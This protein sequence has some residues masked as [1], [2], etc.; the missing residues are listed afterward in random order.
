MEI[1]YHNLKLY[2]IV[3]CTVTL[4]NITANTVYVG[5]EGS[6]TGSGTLEEPFA[7]IT[8]GIS[9]LNPGDTLFV[10]AG[11]YILSTTIQISS[12]QSGQSGNPCYFFAYPGD[13]VM[14][15]FYTQ[16]FGNRGIN[17]K[18]DYW[19]LRDLIVCN[20]GDNGLYIEGAYNLIENCTFYGNDDTG[21]QISGGGSYNIVINCD[22]YNNADPDNED[23]DGFA[24]KLDIGPG[25]E[26]HG[27]RSWNNSDDGWDLYEADDSVVITNCWTFRNG[28]L[29]NESQSGG[30]GNGFKLGGNYVSGNHLVTNC[31]SFGN[32]KYG[33]HQNN[34]IGKITLYNSLG[35]ENVGR[36]YNF[37]YATADSSNL[38]NNISF[39]GGSSDKFTNCHMTTNSWQ[40]LPADEDDFLSLELKMAKDARM[41]DGSL[42]D[43]TFAKL[44]AGSN[45]IDVGTNVGLAYTGTAPDL[46]PFETVSPDADYSLHISTTGEGSVWLSPPGGTYKAGQEV[47]LVARQA[48]NYMFESWSGDLSDVNDTINLT[49]DSDKSVTANFTP[50]S[51]THPDSS[52][53]EA[54]D[55]ILTDYI[56]E[57]IAGASNGKVVR[58]TTTA[59]GSGTV[60]FSGEEHYYRIV[61]RYLDYA[62]GS[63]TYQFSVNNGIIETWNGDVA[64]ITNEYINKTILNVM[65]AEGDI[66]K[67][68]S[69][70]GGQE[71]GRIDCIDV[72]KSEY[73]EPDMIFTNNSG[74]GQNLVHVYPNPFQESL[75]IDFNLEQSQTI[76]IWLYDIDGSMIRTVLDGYFSEGYYFKELP[77]ADLHPGLYLLKMITD[78]G[79]SVIPVV[80]E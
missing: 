21:L 80:K 20:A 17:L 11:R 50:V 43:N 75:T 69:K 5:L 3:L 73:I 31:I 36:N 9:V 34:N 2:W 77:I 1:R 76:K 12:S 74:N 72:I 18:A 29:P 78:K 62:N 42:P 25:N 26:F 70:P 49:M 55:M 13:T 23:A 66:I 32:A 51:D 48:G 44:I 7:T 68:E 14:L 46:G 24:A 40:S 22:S 63:A 57:R 45:L 65:L 8:H 41:P 4:T 64:T 60:T 10:L 53:I 33:Y 19:N 56:F 38:I 58:P 54:E 35:W 28:Y 47:T 16:P 59:F 61:I 39:S 52:R 71:Y 27:C 37:Y 6:D 79:V 15:D 67:I 30:D